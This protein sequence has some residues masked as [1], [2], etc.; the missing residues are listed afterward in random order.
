MKFNNILVFGL[1]AVGSNVI[2]NIIRDISE[3]KILAIDF[4]K[5][6]H[7][8]YMAGTQPYLKQNLNQL[9][10]N[11]LKLIAYQQSGKLINMCNTKVDINNLK[12][13]LNPFDKKDI[14]IIDAFDNADSR[15]LLHKLDYET[16]HIGFSPKMTG[17]AV[18]DRSWSKITDY[19]G[20]VEDICT[21]QG[22]RSFIMS[23]TSIAS[24]VINEFYFNDKKINIYFDS[25]L[26]L[27]IF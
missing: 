19:K 16:I 13:I 25:K 11:S 22:A 4:D 21:Q 7:R 5:V 10:T 23:L 3:V 20:N 12:K 18:W 24:L 2:L 26:N 8:N 17:E 1:G 27:K 14:L 6:E 9:K 15:N